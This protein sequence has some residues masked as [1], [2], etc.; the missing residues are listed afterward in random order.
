MCG[1]SQ[2][3]SP[4]NS[5]HVV[6]HR[7]ASDTVECQ[8]RLQ[9]C[10]SGACNVRLDGNNRFGITVRRIDEHLPV[11]DGR[12]GLCVARVTDDTHC[13]EIIGC[14]RQTVFTVGLSTPCVRDGERHCFCGAV[15]SSIIGSV[16]KTVAPH[17]S[18]RGCIGETTVGIERQ[19]SVGHARIQNGCQR[20]GFRVVIIGQNTRCRLRPGISRG[21][22]TVRVG[23][24]GHPRQQQPWFI[25]FGMLRNS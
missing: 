15:R 17:I 14:F 16:L 20:I 11:T 7:G 8:H 22:V 12:E 13:P 19:R 25:H 23:N 6:I 9:R 4:G 3:R 5:C 10:G 2:S 21:R 18:C 1:K 24:R